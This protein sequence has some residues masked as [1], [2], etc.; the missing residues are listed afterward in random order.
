MS[1]CSSMLSSG[2]AR[3]ALV[4][5]RVEQI[6]IRNFRVFRNVKFTKLPPMAVV[7]GANGTGKSTFFDV[8]SFLKDALVGNATS[9]VA[10]RGGFKE[11]VSRN[12]R[13]PICITIKFRESGGHLASYILEVALKSGRVTV[14]REVLRYGGGVDNGHP[15]H[16]V[17]FSDGSGTVIT[18]ESACGQAGAV[19]CREAFELDDPSTLAIKGWGQFRKFRIASEIRSLIENTYISNLR[20]ADARSNAETGYSEHLSGRGDNIAQTARY[21]YEN[22][23]ARFERVLASMRSQVPGIIDVNA[24]RTEDGRL[25]LRFQDGSFKD[26]F[27]ARYT[28]DGTIKLFAYLILLNAPNPHPVLAVEEPEH[29]LYPAILGNLIEEFR[30][31][32][33]RGG[34]TFVSTYS[35]DFLDGAKLS[36]VYWLEKS[37]GYSTIH[38]AQDHELLKSLV[39]SGDWLG[40]LWRMRLFGNVDPR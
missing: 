20:T 16:L 19:E 17:D 28:S 1:G 37:N 27:I 25:V 34:Q 11:I 26:P 8:F 33:R 31:Y 14:S 23:K 15:W 36:E 4:P 13:G 18:N 38:R 6:E 3:K 12:Q 40:V 22:H 29:Q 7:V 39:D 32:A 10:R 24:K 30:D 9:A 21:L 35:P 5:M 2:G